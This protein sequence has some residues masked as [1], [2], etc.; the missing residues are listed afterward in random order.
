[1]KGA[2]PSRK[3]RVATPSASR[4]TSQDMRSVVCGC[5]K[6]LMKN[7]CRHAESEKANGKDDDDAVADEEK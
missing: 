5:G 2:T 4:H 1:M 7:V 3:E 6:L